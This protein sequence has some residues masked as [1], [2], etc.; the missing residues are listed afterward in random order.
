MSGYD[1]VAVGIIVAIAIAVVVIGLNSDPR[2]KQGYQPKRDPEGM[3]KSPPPNQGNSGHAPKASHR[4][5][6]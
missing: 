5:R 4:R 1:I 6:R 3:P 2:P